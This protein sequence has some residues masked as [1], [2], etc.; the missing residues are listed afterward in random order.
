MI[1]D[2]GKDVFVAKLAKE[3]IQTVLKV[4]NQ[5]PDEKLS[6]LKSAY[7]S[8]YIDEDFII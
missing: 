8:K 5:H 3:D 4:A 1:V 2:Q 6:V 7:I